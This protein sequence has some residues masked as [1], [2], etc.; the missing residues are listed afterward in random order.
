MIEQDYEDLSETFAKAC[1]EADAQKRTPIKTQRL[2]GGTTR[3]HEA[4]LGPWW[5]EPA[6]I[7]ARQFMFGRHYIRGAIGATI[8]GGGRGKTTLGSCEAI[9]MAVGRDLMA[10]E[11]L[12]DGPLRVWVL[13]GE[14]DQNELDRRFA[15]TCRRYGISREDLGGRLFVQSVRDHPWRIATLTKSVASINSEVVGR[16]AAFIK[17]HAIDVFMLDPF[18]SFHAVNE[19][20][21]TDMDLV[22]KEGLGAIASAT[23]SA[24]EIF[25]HPGKPKPGHAAR[26]TRAQHRR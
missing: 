13:N 2:N 10:G 7:P 16:M 19:N 21:N 12:A 22:I 8:G 25:H 23:N 18:V 4:A 5:R 17:E 1:R 20:S 3:D 14:E 11:T 9:S 26:A 15:A 6:D 24:G